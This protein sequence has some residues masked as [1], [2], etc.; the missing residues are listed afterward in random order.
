MD[1]KRKFGYAPDLS[2]QDRAKD[3]EELGRY[4]K[5]RLA[6]AGLISGQGDFTRG[7]TSLL[8][9][10]REQTRLLLDHRCGADQRIE[11]FLSSHLADVDDSD[12]RWLPGRTLVL[13][14]H[15]MAREL[16]IPE[17]GDLF[18]SQYLRS[19][20][21]ANGVL[22]N[23]RNDRRTTKGTFHVTEGGLPIPADKKSVP[24]RT[25]AALLRIAINPPDTVSSLPFD[26]SAKGFVSLLLRPLVAPEVPGFS[27]ALRMETRFFAPGGL[28]SN[29]D[30]V[31]SIFGNA[32]DPFLPENDAGLD[33]KGWS[34]HTGAVI[35]AP[36]LESVTK[37]QVGLP[38]VADATERQKRDGMCWE[39]E[40]EIYNDGSPFKLTCRTKEGVIV[41][42]ISDNYYGYCKK[43]VKTQ[44]SYAA[45]LLGNVEEEH[46]GGAIAFASY[47]LGE[48]TQA[49]SS[50]YGV[51]TLDEAAKR[52]PASIDLQPN[53][54]GR[55]KTFPNLYYIPQHAEISLDS[56]DV[57][58]MRDG[59]EHSLPLIPGKIYMEPS[60][61]RIRMEKH[62][63]A[64]SWR[65][66]GTVPEGVFCH[67]P[68]TVSGGGKSEISKSLRDY[69][70]Y[71]P[72]FVADVEKDF[73]AVQAIF[74][75]DY[76]DRWPQDSPQR[77]VYDSRPSRR[78]LDS[79][80]SLGSVIKLLTPSSLYTD[81][82]NAWLDS[83][84]NHVYSMVLII[85][86]FYKPELGP[87]W[88]DRFRVDISNGQPGHELI[89]YD[90]KL[91]GTYLRVGVFGETD[92]ANIQ[93]STGFR[94]GREDSDRGRH[95]SLDCRASRHLTGL[96][97]DSND[98]IKF[99]ENCEFRLFQRP[100]D[101]IHRGLDKRTEADLARGGC[102]LS[103]FEP[104]S[105]TEIRKMIDKVADLDRFS[106]PMRDFLI[107]ASA[108][109]ERPRRVF[110][111]FPV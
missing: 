71:G 42:L 9:S 45:N 17:H 50:K 4:V 32:G 10:Y 93:M 68:C 78:I 28:V 97:D 15:G 22:H 103:N 44:L 82:F 94:F 37:K 96:A 88:R 18:Q 83:I 99:A 111:L 23:P 60:G 29:L 90:R 76:S 102:F 89:H 67:K 8:A 108:T 107:S 105:S 109:E 91:V 79:A 12:Q 14:Q 69:M 72:V 74:D 35:L 47:S 57:R 86:R 62:P 80:R 101:G 43:E 56:Q 6:A 110:R 25:F 13:D 100:D 2:A 84:P 65:L 66:R 3:R 59:T 52:Y 5:L 16:S 46:A 7:T 30:F 51:M 58:W 1:L 34:G 87:D 24:K 63:A 49:R 64:P 81:K 98:S 27:S 77:Q 20:R 75:R 95:H 19:Y 11:D 48:S 104:L 31:E 85:K 36:H 53:G 106:P 38:H 40:D 54:Y 61:Y 55:D 92:L 33:I 70:L 26:P 41:T 39:G 21:V 73:D